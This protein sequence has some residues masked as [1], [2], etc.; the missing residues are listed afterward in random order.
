MLIRRIIVCL[1]P[2][3]HP[4]VPNTADTCRTAPPTGSA[5]SYQLPASLFLPSLRIIFSICVICRDSWIM[6]HIKGY[7]S[8]SY[9][10]LCHL[11][12][13]NLISINISLSFSWLIGEIQWVLKSNDIIESI[14]LLLQSSVVSSGELPWLLIVIN[15]SLLPLL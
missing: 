14:F 4:Y 15:K 7:M 2:P 13:F 9:I 12:L 5:R 8:K 3:A 1:H 11:Y 6:P 10:V